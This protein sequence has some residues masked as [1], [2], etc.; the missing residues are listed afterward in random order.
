MVAILQWK[1][2]VHI[3]DQRA[4]SDKLRAVTLTPTCHKVK[5]MSALVFLH[6]PQAA[7]QTLWSLNSFPKLAYF[8]LTRRFR[9]SVIFPRPHKMSRI[10]SLTKLGQNWQKN[11]LWIMKK[12]LLE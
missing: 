8:F 12:E 11:V 4:E 10:Q 9:P 2:Y 5:E 7:G 1:Q 6:A 3:L